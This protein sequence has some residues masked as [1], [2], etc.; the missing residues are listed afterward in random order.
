MKKVLLFFGAFV[1]VVALFF[2]S[3][4]EAQSFRE[5]K[6]VSGSSLVIKEKATTNS[7]TLATLTR[8]DFVTVYSAGNGWSYV[9]AKDKKGYVAT[10]FLATP[11]SSIKIA[12]SKG[13]LV[14][15][16]AASRSAKTVATLQYSMIVEDFGAVNDEWSFVQYGNVT[17][18]VV[19]SF[20]GTPNTKAQVTKE[21]VSLRNIAS[22][23]GAV[24]GTLPAGTKVAVHSAIA[25]WSFVSNGNNK[26]YVETVKLQNVEANKVAYAKDYLPACPK[27]YTFK[28]THV[29]N[30][31]RSTEYKVSTCE[32]RDS[33]RWIE[34]VDDK[35]SLTANYYTLRGPEMHI[36]QYEGQTLYKFP[37]HT[38]KS[39]TH[40]AYVEDY[41]TQY[42]IS[43]NETVTTPAGTFFDVIK[44]RTTADYS[45]SYVYLAPYIGKVKSELYTNH[46]GQ[47][48][49][50][51]SELYSMY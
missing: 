19:T 23:S 40:R 22:P 18:Y 35:Y 45:V 16:E 21:N 27:T 2:T 8:G 7:R 1:L 50:G 28:N 49:S 34:D 42:V 15:K 9:Q 39:W 43:V 44:I 48:Y 30:G 5:V 25:G 46:N 4:A 24:K 36:Q 47:T 20:I 37:L 3:T 33:G 17:G 31:E 10:S 11:K 29:Q 51:V 26:G 14:V 32:F 6:V 12:S 41:V 13:G 38:G